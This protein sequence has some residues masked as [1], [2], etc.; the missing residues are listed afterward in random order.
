[1]L[2]KKFFITRLMTTLIMTCVVT[3]QYS[4]HSI[5]VRGAETIDAW[6]GTPSWV[7]CAG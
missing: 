1:M 4:P 6:S 2:P 5:R 3:D 7:A